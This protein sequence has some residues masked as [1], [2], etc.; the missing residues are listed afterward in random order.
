ML[1][2]EFGHWKTDSSDIKTKYLIYIID[3]YRSPFKLITF[4]PVS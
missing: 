3:I 2:R 4:V 1:K